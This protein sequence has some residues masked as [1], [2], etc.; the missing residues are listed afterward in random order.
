MLIETALALLLIGIL[1]LLP[2]HIPRPVERHARRDVAVGVIA[3]VFSLAVVWGVLSKPAPT[4]TVATEYVRLAPAAHAKDVVTAIL[5]DFRG[6]DTMG[7]ITVL[8][9]A[10][11][12]TA[13]LL[14]RGRLWW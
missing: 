10:L 4:G 13:T 3:G 5:A 6:L 11:L 14:Q 12:G 9:V 7:E 1:S 8:A 2:R